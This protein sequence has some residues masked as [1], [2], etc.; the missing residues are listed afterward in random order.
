MSFDECRVLEAGGPRTRSRA[1]IN[2]LVDL[3]AGSAF[4][5]SVLSGKSYYIHIVAGLALTA[6]VTAH[7]GL[8]WNWF[9]A[10]SRRL[11]IWHAHRRVRQRTND[12]VD[13]F[14]AAM[15]VISTASGLGLL[16]ADSAALG[17]IH[18]LSGWMFV[19]GAAV[20]IALHRRWVVSMLRRSSTRSTVSTVPL[21]R[22]ALPGHGPG[23]LEGGIVMLSNAGETPPV[24]DYG[25][26]TS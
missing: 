4:V 24:A 20:H 13:V 21:R 19:L 7:L 9:A 5:L 14:I 25:G 22:T 23:Q 8:H 6:A 11:S 12:L 18:G 1:R 2:F 10:F 3:T 17:K 16:S 26:E 15:F